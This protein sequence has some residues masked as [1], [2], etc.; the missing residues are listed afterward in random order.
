MHCLASPYANTHHIDHG[1]LEHHKIA[2]WNSFLPAQVE[3]I[4]SQF[5]LYHVASNHLNFR[6]D[7]IISGCLHLIGHYCNQFY[8]WQCGPANLNP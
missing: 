6:V 3:A 4:G 7:L 5:G 2:F 8:F 1:L